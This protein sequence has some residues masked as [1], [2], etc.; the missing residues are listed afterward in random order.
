M[1]ANCNQTSGGTPAS[2]ASLNKRYLFK[3][4]SN[5]IG[6]GASGAT[7]AIIPRGL[8][9]QAYGDFSFLTSFF[10]LTVNNLEMGTFQ[11]FY[12][13]LSQRPQERTLVGFYF[14]FVAVMAAL[15]VGFV[16]VAHRSEINSFLWPSQPMSYVYLAAGW[17]IMIWFVQVLE[18]MG[19]GYGLTISTEMARVAQKVMWLV[20]IIVLFSLQKL[21]LVNF[22]LFCYINT[23]LIILLFLWIMRSKGYSLQ[24]IWKFHPGQITAYAR[25]F[26]T[27][28]HPLFTFSLIGMGANLFDRWL[29]QVFSGSVQQGF[30]GLSYQIG[31]L[32]FVF[33]GAMTPLITREFA[34]AFGKNDL[35]QMAQ[36]FRRYIPMLYSVA[37]FLACFVAVQADKITYIIGG[38]SFKG[39]VMAVTI[40]AFYPIYQTYGQLSGSVFYATGQTALYRNIGIIF[41]LAGV[42]MTYLLVAPANKMGLDAGATGLAL[43]L[44]LIQVLANNVQLYFNARFL[45]LSFRRY[46][47][48]QFGSV[49]CFLTIS[50]LVASGL[51]QSG[52]LQDNYILNLVL[53]LVLYGA[54][55]LIIALFRPALFGL[56]QGDLGRL[57]QNLYAEKSTFFR[58][59]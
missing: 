1:A 42:P 12:T 57:W 25:E 33:S 52:V 18:G 39:A 51:N 47:L 31:I 6:L 50:F 34:V 27:Y 44:V 53:A 14:S 41:L 5:I 45:K 15:V 59:D 54:V 11:G 3:L 7:Q 32:C 38:Q 9:P 13:K 20:W 4:V 48:H 37:A 19:D 36:L 2:G 8:G 17:A 35:G 55:V 24:G 26:F 21:N 29:L 23:V 46:V 16:M 49:I 28:S 58:N 22:F 43:K 30:Y 40:M 56:R 10:S